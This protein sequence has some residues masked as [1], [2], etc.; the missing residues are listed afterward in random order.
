MQ[1]LRQLGN[2][3]LLGI[4]SVVVVLGAFALTMAEGGYMAS[5]KPTA[6]PSQ[7]YPTILPTLPL[8]L[9]TEENTSAPSATIMPSATMCPPPNGWVGLTVQELDTADSIALNYNIPAEQFKA[10]NCL[11]QDVLIAGSIVYVPV[12]ATSTRLPCGAP[13]WWVNYIVEPGDT[14]YAIGLRYQTGVAQLQQ[15]N[16]LGNSITIYAGQT[17]KV[18]NVPT[19]VPTQVPTQTETATATLTIPVPVATSTNTVTPEFTTEAPIP[20]TETPSE[21]IEPPSETPNPPT[22]TEEPVI[23]SETPTP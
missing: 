13:A 16:C 18:P 21:T 6:T 23:P 3:F 20:A 1:P 2:G 17:I 7:T 4:I 15:A 22:E 5:T 11:V 12:Q 19:R 9:P 8:L 14:L 10:A